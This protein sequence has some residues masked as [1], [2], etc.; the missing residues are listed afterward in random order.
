M[1]I[2]GAEGSIVGAKALS[3]KGGYTS[4]VSSS[5]TARCGT[6]PGI[7]GQ[8]VSATNTVPAILA[9]GKFQAWPAASLLLVDTIVENAA[10]RCPDF[11]QQC[12]LARN[13]LADTSAHATIAWQVFSTNANAANAVAMAMDYANA[14]QNAACDAANS[15]NLAARDVANCANAFSMDKSIAVAKLIAFFATV[16]STAAWQD[17]SLANANA[18]NAAVCFVDLQQHYS[19]ANAAFANAAASMYWCLLTLLAKAFAH[20]AATCC[21]CSRASA[22]RVQHCAHT[23]GGQERHF[24]AAT[25]E[26]FGPAEYG[27]GG[28]KAKG[29]WF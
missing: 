7:S 22:A 19:L 14:P 3:Y 11:R 23:V 6:V 29:G 26:S 24:N 27:G 25:V 15:A 4:T 9:V 20:T 16:H 5:A 1:A 8:C 2:G 17:C 28:G 13:L 21:C 10:A 12:S 18:A